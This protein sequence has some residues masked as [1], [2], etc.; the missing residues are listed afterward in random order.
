MLELELVLLT[1]LSYPILFLVKLRFA[2]GRE[3]DVSNY[4]CPADNSQFTV[5]EEDTDLKFRLTMTPTTPTRG[6]GCSEEPPSVTGD[7]SSWDAHHLNIKMSNRTI[8]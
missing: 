3:L 8:R 4:L 2:G 5:I 7:E 1:S 6:C